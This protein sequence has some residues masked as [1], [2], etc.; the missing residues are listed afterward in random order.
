MSLVVVV[1]AASF[2][3]TGYGGTKELLIALGLPASSVLLYGCRRRVQDGERLTLRDPTR[4]EA[5]P[6]PEVAR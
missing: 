2:S 3:I 5:A 1:G 6:T 4:V